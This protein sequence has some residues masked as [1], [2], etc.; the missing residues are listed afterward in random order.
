MTSGSDLVRADPSPCTL[1][2]GGA[3]DAATIAAIHTA[4]WRTAYRGVLEDEFLDGPLEGYSEHRWK[5]WFTMIGAP[6]SHIV[7][8][9]VDGRVVGFACI[10]HCGGEF[11]DLLSNLHVLADAR[12]QGVGQALLAECARLTHAQGGEAMHLWVYSGNSAA[13]GF[14]E[15]QGGLAESE[16]DQLAADGHMRPSWR[17]L[18][19]DLPGLFGEE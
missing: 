13:I 17:Y 10:V 18:W 2:L 1:R 14:Y 4:S 8:A 3:A 16:Q 6:P 19:R 15:H 9:E 12:G 7:L 5:T 11:G